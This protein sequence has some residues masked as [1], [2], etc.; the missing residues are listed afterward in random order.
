MNL[1]EIEKW[2]IIE[3]QSLDEGF[4]CNWDV[5]ET[6]LKTDRLLTFSY[7]N[8]TIGFCVFSESE[9]HVNIDILEIAPQYRR[10]G[11]GGSF[12]MDIEH[13]FRKKGFLAIELCCISRESER[14]WISLDFIRFP[15]MRY[16]KSDLK[17][18]KPLV[19]ILKPNEDCN[20]NS[21]LELWDKEP[22]EIEESNAPVW[23]WTVN[24]NG[25]LEKPILFPC[26][27]DWNLRWR[28]GNETIRD[29]KVKYFT[30]KGELYFSGYLYVEKL[31]M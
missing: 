20:S 15:K 1:D 14:F 31:E 2:L 26:H 27:F 22:Y 29:D 19:E 3:N 10:K 24:E 4:Y 6:A 28:R 9:K 17:F 21:V 18:Y 25:S 30:K 7:E 5:I 12:Y 8:R 11:L 23:V 13:H 16:S